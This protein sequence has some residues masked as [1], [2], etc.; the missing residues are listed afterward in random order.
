[1]SFEGFD[2]I[3]SIE[4]VYATSGPNADRL[5]ASMFTGRVILNG[6]LGDDTLFG[7]GGND[8]LLGS[9]GNDLIFG[10]AG[11]DTLDGSLGEDK[12]F[13]DADNDTFTNFSFAVDNELVDNDLVD[14]GSV[15]MRYWSQP[16][17]IIWFSQTRN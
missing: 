4:V 7:A 11:D 15:S 8:S 3:N 12:L 6:Y 16:I 5:D 2:L 1:M 10:G 13:G 9:G 17:Q 14:G